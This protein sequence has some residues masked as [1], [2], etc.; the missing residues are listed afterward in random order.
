V[1]AIRVVAEEFA[2][3]EMHQQLQPQPLQQP[4][5]FQQLQKSLQKQLRKLQLLKSS[6]KVNSFLL[7]ISE[8]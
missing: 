3:L 8:K 4:P 6:Q 5:K 1:V 7:P 2:G